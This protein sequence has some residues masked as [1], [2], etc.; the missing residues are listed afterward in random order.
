MDLSAPVNV[1]RRVNNTM[2]VQYLTRNWYTQ[3]YHRGLLPYR[4]LVN[5]LE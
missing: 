2:T 4:T 5:S 3:Q 1:Y